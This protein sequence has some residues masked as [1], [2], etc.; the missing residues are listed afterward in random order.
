MKIAGLDLSITSSGVSILTISDHFDVTNVEAFGFTEHRKY[1]TNHIIF[2]KNDDFRDHYDKFFFMFKYILDW[3]KDCDYVAVEDYAMGSTGATGMIFDLGEF[4]GFIRLSL[5]EQRK[6]LRFYAI[7]SIK[8]FWT[9]YGLSDKISMYNAFINF[10]GIKPD[11]SQFKPV[12]NGHGSKTISDIVDS[13]AIVMM[14]LTELQY[15]AKIKT[16]TSD[17]DKAIFL[18]SKKNT[19]ILAHDF[20][21]K[22]E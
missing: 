10:N 19:G 8:K 16:I 1:S 21:E 9:G 7:N 11:I 13:F 22:L 4:E 20:I 17:V 6:K 15:R 12:T 5:F 18:G 3:V 2:Y 14:L